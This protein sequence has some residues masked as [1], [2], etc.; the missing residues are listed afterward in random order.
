MALGEG[1]GTFVGDVGTG[2]FDG[3]AFG[4][5][6]GFAP[7]AENTAGREKTGLE[8]WEAAKSGVFAELEVE[9]RRV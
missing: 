1:V 4:V 9:S 7:G 5:A 2:S 3:P 8:V 6:E